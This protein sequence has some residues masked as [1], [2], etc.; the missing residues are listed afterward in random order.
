MI[1]KLQ[2]KRVGSTWLSKRGFEPR[3][4]E[5]TGQEPMWQQMGY[6]DAIAYRNEFDAD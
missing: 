3:R 1:L 5:H 6:S 4:G 2:F